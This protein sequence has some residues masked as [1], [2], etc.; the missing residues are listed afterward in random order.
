MPFL[1]HG[2]GKDA[3]VAAGARVTAYVAEK[4]DLDPIRFE[5]SGQGPKADAR[6]ALPLSGLSVISFQNQSG[7][8]AVVR[9]TGPSAQVLTVVDGQSSSARVAAGDYY[10]LV[11][12]GGSLA[13]YRF[14]KAGPIAVTETGGQHSVVHITLRR[15]VADNPKAQEEFYKGQ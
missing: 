9:L 7:G 6:I 3:K 15:P 14:E 13:E 12:Y 5:P 8:E 4:M 2:H 11:R 1:M 10:I